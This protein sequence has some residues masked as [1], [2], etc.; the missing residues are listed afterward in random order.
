[1]G[2]DVIQ[3]ILTQAI[4]RPEEGARRVQKKVFSHLT[5]P[6]ETLVVS[7]QITPTETIQASIESDAVVFTKD[8]STTG[9]QDKEMFA[10]I[11]QNM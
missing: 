7:G 4:E 9:I 1:M 8:T 10:K 3:F 11:S 6:I 2:E 5:E